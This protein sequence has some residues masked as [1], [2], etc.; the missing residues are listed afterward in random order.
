MIGLRIFRSNEQRLLGTRDE[1]L[2]MSAGEAKLRKLPPSV[3]FD[4]SSVGA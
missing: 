3:S 4:I 1:P 2:R